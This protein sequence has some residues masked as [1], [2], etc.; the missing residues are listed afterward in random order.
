MCFPPS[1]VVAI[2]ISFFS[3]L[4]SSC[5]KSTKLSDDASPWESGAGTSGSARC[6]KS[7]PV[8]KETTKSPLSESLLIE[9]PVRNWAV[10]FLRKRIFPLL[11]KQT[12]NMPS[13]DIRFSRL[14]AVRFLFSPFDL[15]SPILHIVMLS[16]HVRLKFST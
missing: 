5:G 9:L 14:P 6:A 7:N 1:K 4:C 12:Y 10:R 2:L 3:Q 15:S 16:Y 11:K 13:K 8:Y